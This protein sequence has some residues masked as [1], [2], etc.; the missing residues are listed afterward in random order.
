AVVMPYRDGVSFRRTTLIAALRHGCAIVTTTPADPRLSP[1]IKPG[2]NMLLVP[3]RQAPALAQAITALAENPALRQ[4]IA[5]GA[6]QLSEL[7][8]WDQIAGQ[9]LKVYQALT[10]T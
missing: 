10:Q 3:P 9:T 2:E 5:Q 8:N 4:Q 6:R 7:F 1:E